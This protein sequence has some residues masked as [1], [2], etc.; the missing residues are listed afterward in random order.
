M[1]MQLNIILCSFLL[2]TVLKCVD[3]L[4]HTHLLDLLSRE[5]EYLSSIHDNDTHKKAQLH[6]F[7]GEHTEF[8]TLMNT[9]KTLRCAAKVARECRWA[10]NAGCMKA[11]NGI[12]I[13]LGQQQQS[14]HRRIHSTPPAILPGGGSTHFLSIDDPIEDDSYA[15]GWYSGRRSPSPPPPLNQSAGDTTSSPPQAHHRRAMS[16]ARPIMGHSTFPI[17]STPSSSGR[18]HSPLRSTRDSSLFRLIVTLQLC[19]VR[20]EEANS[21]LCDGKADSGD[22]GCEY[23]RSSS[24]PLVSSGRLVAV[25]VTIGSVFVLSSRLRAHHV[26]SDLLP[27]A[28]KASAG[29]ATASLIRRQWRILCMNARVANSAAATEE[30]ILQ[31]ICLVNN[32]GTGM[33]AGYKNFISPRKVRQ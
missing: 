8:P 27:L 28:G 3:R 5:M 6:Q 12:G 18:E 7:F 17:L 19:L 1:D 31:W 29:M 14:L 25:G 13:D 24:S 9:V 32:N 16:D 11:K 23:P 15:Q 4:I 33:D 26:Q 22:R 21:I 20:L 2:F 10:T 30:W